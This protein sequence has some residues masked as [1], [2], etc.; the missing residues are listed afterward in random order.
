MLHPAA[1]R[2]LRPLNSFVM[3]RKA[4]WILRAVKLPESTDEQVQWFHALAALPREQ[5]CRWA[6]VTNGADFVKYIEQHC[7]S[8]GPP[9]FV[10][11]EELVN[12][13]LNFRANE[14]AWNKALQKVL[15]EAHDLHAQQA[16]HVSAKLLNEF[17]SECPWCLFREVAV[18]QALHYRSLIVQGRNDA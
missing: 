15:A 3:H 8:A 2:W 4:A 1:R 11:V 10:G 14:S 9:S 17:A 16:L 5:L 12:S 13:V 6:E 18:N 7:P